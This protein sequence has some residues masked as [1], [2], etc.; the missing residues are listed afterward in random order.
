MKLVFDRSDSF[1]KIF[2]SVEKIPDGKSV[3]IEIHPHNQFFKNIRRGKQ[4]VEL[5]KEKKIAYTISTNSDFVVA[6]FSELGEKAELQEAHTFKKSAHLVYNFLFNIKKFHL[7]MFDK[8]D[9]LSFIVLWIESL[10]L[11][12]A[13]YIF[14]VILVPTSVLSIKPSYNLEEIA[15]NFRYYP[16]ESPLW[17]Q[18]TKFI[19]IPY[20]KSNIEHDL[21]FSVP[22]SDLKYNVINAQWFVKVTNTLNTQLTLKPNTKF[23]TDD[24]LLYKS[25]EWITVPGRWSIVVPVESLEKDEKD[26]II[27]TRGNIQ[28]GTKLQVKNLQGSLKSKIEVLSTVNFSGGKFFTEGII[29]DKDISNFTNKANEQIVK[30]KR[31]VLIKQLKTESTKPLLF[32][33]MIDIEILSINLNKKAWDVANVVDGTIKAKL[34]YR[35]IYRDELMSAVYKFTAQ[36]P[37]Q[38][39]SLLEIDRNSTVLFDR[40]VSST[41][42][43]IIPTKVNTV[44]WYNF[45]SDVGGIKNQ[46]KTKIRGMSKDEAQKTLLTFPSVWSASIKIS[47]FRVNTIP[48]VLSRIKIEVVK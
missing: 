37:N 7:Q 27:W 12:I 21:A 23:M 11:L 48:N 31:D 19:S 30:I 44:R 40:F 17:W 29:S 41:G 26:Q 15:Y 14:Y 3:D 16:I 33:D 1:Y 35:Y 9:Y 2:K 24:G 45:T 36:R 38:S 39:F 10:I 43:Y 13:L 28:A 34:I 42:V 20:Y 8:K 5:L 32:D 4:L 25:L 46:I 6:Y 18:D 47:P 22:L